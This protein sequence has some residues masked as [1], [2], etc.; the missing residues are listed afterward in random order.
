MNNLIVKEVNF[1]GDNLIAAQSNKDGK[2][3]VGVSNICNVLNLS[4]N[5]KDRQVKN[6]Q[7]D[8]V[9]NKGCVKFDVGVFDCNN[10]TLAIQIDFLPLWLAKISITPKMKIDSPNVVEKLI[11][12]QLKAK[13]VLAD[14]FIHNNKN[15][16]QFA[17]PQTLSEALRLAADLAEENEILKPKAESYDTFLTGENFQTFNQVA[18][19]LKTGRNKLFKFLRDKEILM[20][21]NLPYQTYIDRQLFKVREVNMQRGNYSFNGNQTLVSAKGVV[22]IEK[23]IAKEKGLPSTATQFQCLN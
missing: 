7:T 6:I 21:N 1:N 4:K 10:E 16:N 14:A 3:Y 22:F 8:I 20:W 17:I 18:K 23:L 9:L 19:S 13:D 12:Y 15:D 2:I 11:E 5:G